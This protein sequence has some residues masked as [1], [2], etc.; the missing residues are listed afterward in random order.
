MSLS[1]NHKIER[2]LDAVKELYAQLFLLLEQSALED[3]LIRASTEL[4]LTIR[5][6]ME[7]V[8]EKMDHFRQEETLARQA[9]SLSPAVDT[10]IKDFND[11]L[12]RG[13]TAMH[14]RLDERTTAMA[15]QRDEM[16]DKLKKANHKKRGMKGYG[17][18]RAGAKFIE[19]EI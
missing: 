6:L 19:S 2:E 11:S 17:I 9:G 3:P 13:L 5:R 10:S 14:G 15:R 1:E 18:P 4:D 7:R 8:D 16:R 12:A